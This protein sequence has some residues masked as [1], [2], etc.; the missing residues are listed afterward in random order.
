MMIF[1]AGFRNR[2]RAMITGRSR[3]RSAMSDLSRRK[4]FTAGLATAAGD[5]AC[6]SDALPSVMD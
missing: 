2:M 4:L 1:L 6:G 3:L 5:P